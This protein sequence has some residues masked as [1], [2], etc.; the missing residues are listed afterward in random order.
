MHQCVIGELRSV[1]FGNHSVFSTLD[2]MFLLP[3]SGPQS[4]PE[5][6]QRPENKENS[7]SL[8]TFEEGSSYDD[9]DQEA[10]AK[11]SKPFIKFQS[12]RIFIIYI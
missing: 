5:P 6:R 10:A 3:G 12:V 2:V 11:L 9:F 7:S 8:S 1:Q 4:S